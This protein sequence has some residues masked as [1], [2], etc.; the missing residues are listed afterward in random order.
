MDTTAAIALRK[1]SLND[2]TD[3]PPEDGQHINLTE[4]YLG[5]NQLTTLP[6]ERFGSS[7][8]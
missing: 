4:L 6:P 5:N 8:I 1:L 2:L 3:L 7:R